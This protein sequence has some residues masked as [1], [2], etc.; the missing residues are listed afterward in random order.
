[1]LSILIR[2]FVKSNSLLFIISI[3]L[4][5]Q[6]G[7]S[8]ILKKMRRNYTREAYLELANKI[9]AKIHGVT[10]SSD[11]ICGFCGETED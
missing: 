4:P 8:E 11:F 9:R 10:L 6:S 1:M 3:H 5:A 7:S 2:I